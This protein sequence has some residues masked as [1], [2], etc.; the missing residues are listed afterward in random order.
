[1]GRSIGKFAFA[2]ILLATAF[3]PT[4]AVADLSPTCKLG[5]MKVRSENPFVSTKSTAF[6]M[7]P[8][9][10]VSFTKGS[11]S[12][13]VLVLFSAQVAVDAGEVLIAGPFMD[14]TPQ[15]HP[16]SVFM[17]QETNF[18]TRS[19]A[20]WFSGIP[21]GTHNVKMKWRAGG[22]TGGAIK[23]FYRTLVVEYPPP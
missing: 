14:D 10:G 8:K 9:M 2:A 3:A 13:C 4:T 15:A 12:S 19:F 6:V 21:A 18:G 5:A 23:M 1:M 16:P 11:A 20:F 7:I 17:T 22:E